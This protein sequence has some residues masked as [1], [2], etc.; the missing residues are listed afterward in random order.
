MNKKILVGLL[1]IVAVI[2]YLN[3][4]VVLPD[5][6]IGISFRP[7][8]MFDGYVMQLTN[9]HSTPIQVM[10]YVVNKKSGE[11]GRWS[12]PISYGEKKEVGVLETNCSF[13]PGEEGYVKIQG[14]S[15]KLHY[16]L[17]NRGKWDV[18]FGL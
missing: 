14:Y 5:P 3:R 4:D 2:F 16:R 15:K 9:T 12:F 10:L 7:S 18:W 6:P 8:L 13:E 11:E 1:I 17:S